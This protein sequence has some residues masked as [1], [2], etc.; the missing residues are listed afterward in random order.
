[1]PED[2][3][4]YEAIGGELHVSP[5]PK[6]P[7][8]WVSA[9]LFAA[10]HDLLVRPGDGYLFAAPTGVEFPDT[11]EGVQ[12]DL[13]FITTERFHIATEDWI[14]GPP[15]L[16]IEILSPST[17]RRDRTVKRHLYERQGVAEYW[18]VDLDARQVEVW[19]FAAGVTQPERDTDRLPVRLGARVVGGIELAKVFDW[20]PGP[21]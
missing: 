4:R 14:Q 6:V 5:P 17:A 19:R 20:P 18:I 3:N 1:M 7:H 16:V 21:T 10:L 15:D 2:G 9:R 8:Q 12:P 11:E 13:L